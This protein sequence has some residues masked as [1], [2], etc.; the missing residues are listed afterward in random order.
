MERSISKP[1]SASALQH[2][3]NYYLSGMPPNLS[4]I[5]HPNRI[6]KAL[7]AVQRRPPLFSAAPAC[8]LQW[9]FPAENSISV[10]HG[11]V[12]IFSEKK[13]PRGC[14][15]SIISPL[16]LGFFGIGSGNGIWPAFLSKLFVRVMFRPRKISGYRRVV[17]WF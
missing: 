15:Q 13:L 6:A 1:V 12:C 7:A 4:L 16:N 8:N 11:A 5:G 9:I 3:Q 17:A 2:I 10:N 14:T